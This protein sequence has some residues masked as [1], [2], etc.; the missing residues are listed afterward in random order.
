MAAMRGQDDRSGEVVD[1]GRERKKNE[2]R[3]RR[4]VFFFSFFF[5]IMIRLLR[6]DTV[7]KPSANVASASSREI[8]DTN[9]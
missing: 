4:P 9:D 5:F 8:L 3:P 2:S 7:C 1:L 6:K